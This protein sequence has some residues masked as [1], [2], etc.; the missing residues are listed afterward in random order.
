MLDSAVS[1]LSLMFVYMLF[2]RYDGFPVLSLDLFDPVEGLR[3]PSSRLA[4]RHSC[5]TS[6]APMFRRTKQVSRAV[7]HYHHALI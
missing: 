3:T 4:A 6:P 1:L 5:P 7:T 2:I